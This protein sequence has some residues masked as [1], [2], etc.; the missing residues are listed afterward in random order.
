VADLIRVRN[1][2]KA[3]LRIAYNS[4]V[5]VIPKD[6][7]AFVDREAAC[8]HFGDWTLRN[9]PMSP[10]PEERDA[11]RN[12]FYRLKGMYGAHAALESDSPGL[13][14]K[15]RP[16]VQLF[17]MD[18]TPLPSVIEDPEGESLTA[19]DPA[20]INRDDL[21]R[22]MHSQMQAMAERLEELESSP[23]E[24]PEVPEDTPEQA[25]PR[26][27]KRPSVQTPDIAEEG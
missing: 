17:E 7:E 14:A 16:H 24:V 10:L 8:I 9:R 4:Q 5:T 13:W 1:V 12:E 25:S 2:G 11:R 27:A 20:D 18:G 19:E 21:I 26:R 15:N 23:V 22:T 6:G 3:N